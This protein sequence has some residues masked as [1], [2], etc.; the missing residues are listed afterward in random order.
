MAPV[1]SEVCL[2][3]GGDESLNDLSLQY[4][5]RKMENN[6]KASLRRIFG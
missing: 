4:V 6:S 3:G 2:G 5:H 1:R